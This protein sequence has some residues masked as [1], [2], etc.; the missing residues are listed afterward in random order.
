MIDIIM[1][2]GAQVLLWLAI[3]QVMRNSVKKK[4]AKNFSKIA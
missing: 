2:E 4:K 1:K 3:R